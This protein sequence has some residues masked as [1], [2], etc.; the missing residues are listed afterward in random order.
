MSELQDINSFARKFFEHEFFFLGVNLLNSPKRGR[1][2]GAAFDIWNEDD[3]ENSKVI[4]KSS[5]DIFKEIYGY[6]TKMFTPPAMF[7]NP[8]IEPVLKKEGV[9]L[10][11]VGRYFK[12]PR[13]Y[14][15][16]LPQF[17][18][19]GKKR[20]S[21]LKVLVRNCMYETNISEIENGVNRAMYDIEQAFK[22]K[23][24]A[25]ISNHRAS[26]VG[27]ITKTNRDNGLLS[28]DL[29]FKEILKKWPDAEFITSID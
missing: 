29:L 23:Q 24:P 10:L 16:D 11:D 19:L 5:L 9:E 3:L 27:G 4:A 17:N 14:G 13:L 20:K 18:Y 1:G 26:F 2:I 12:I 28:L 25:I 21:G 22:L 7:Y 15:K 6:R 8:K